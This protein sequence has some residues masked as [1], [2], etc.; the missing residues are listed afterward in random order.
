[1][2]EEWQGTDPVGLPPKPK[3]ASLMGVNGQWQ[4]FPAPVGTR[5]GRFRPGAGA[6]W[7]F[8]TEI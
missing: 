7:N 4:A 1:M 2:V 5:G 3:R 6:A 8:N